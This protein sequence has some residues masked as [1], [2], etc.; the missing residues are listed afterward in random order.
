MRQYWCFEM[1]IKTKAP[2]R[3]RKAAAPTV[4]VVQQHAATHLHYDFRLEIN[5]VMKSWAIPKGPSLN[6]S[7]RR[8]AILTKDHPM[9]YN[10]FEGVIPKGEYGAGTVIIWDRGRYRNLKKNAHKEP[11]SIES[12]FRKGTIE[13]HLNG[14]KMKGGFALI[15]TSGKNWLL[16]KMND[17]YANTRKNLAQSEPYSV[18]SGKTLAQVKREKSHG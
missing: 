4:F 9:A 8:L 17:R 10:R 14:K 13:V 7:E 11:L 12:C 1:G 6:P 15:R 18:K 2:F 5:G 16:I 3:R